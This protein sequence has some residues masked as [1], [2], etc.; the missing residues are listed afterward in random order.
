MLPLKITVERDD[1][2]GV[3]IAIEDTIGLA[4]EASTIGALCDRLKVAIPEMMEANRT[5]CT[6]KR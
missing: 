6:G 1:E 3:W 2:A 4:I 5:K